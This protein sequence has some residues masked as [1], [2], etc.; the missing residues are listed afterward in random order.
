MAFYSN[1][2]SQWPAFPMNQSQGNNKPKYPSTS[3]KFYQISRDCNLPFELFGEIIVNRSASD[4]PREVPISGF[5]IISPNDLSLLISKC[6]SSQSNP[7]KSQSNVS[8]VQPKIKEKNQIKPDA[9][10]NDS[11]EHQIN[12]DKSEKEQLKSNQGTIGDASS[13]GKNMPVTQKSGMSLSHQELTDP[14]SK[15]ASNK[16]KKSQAQ[17]EPTHQKN[18][19][20]LASLLENEKDKT[21]RNGSVSKACY[22]SS[23]GCKD[24]FCLCF[25]TG[26]KCSLLCE[27]VSCENK[28]PNASLELNKELDLK[29]KKREKLLQDTELVQ[30]KIQEE[31]KKLEADK[32]KLTQLLSGLYCKV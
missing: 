14:S 11:K 17:K 1:G 2:L 22:C 6:S 23:F 13:K 18:I 28:A 12:Q 3:S 5:Y 27:C 32:A 15:K 8:M 20:F 19:D 30:R 26:N 21:L 10:K 7:P 9:F 31:K 16:E 25:G 29:L 4:P 24:K